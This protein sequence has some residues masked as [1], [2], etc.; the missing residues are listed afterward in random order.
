MAEQKAISNVLEDNS[1]QIPDYPDTASDLEAPK[2]QV[3]IY[4]L[5]LVG[6]SVEEVVRIDDIV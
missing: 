5:T 4:A 2:V 1:L 3:T 6:V